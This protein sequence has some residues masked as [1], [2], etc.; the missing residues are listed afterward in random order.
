MSGLW[1]GLAEQREQEVKAC[2]EDWEEQQCLV[3]WDVPICLLFILSFI[4]H[5]VLLIK[6]VFAR[7]AAWLP[8]CQSV[9]T[10][11]SL[12]FTHSL[13]VCLSSFLS[14]FL[15]ACLS[16]CFS[17]RQQ[18]CPFYLSVCLF[19]SSLFSS[20]CMNFHDGQEIKQH[21]LFTPPIKAFQTPHPCCLSVYFPSQAHHKEHSAALR[22]LLNPEIRSRDPRP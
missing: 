22:L 14:D 18:A 13:S 3:H 21:H 11:H 16:A 12:H 10:R 4:F 17:V 8:A 9:F 6:R 19:S 1:R 5:S 15:P 7:L 2:P 20:V